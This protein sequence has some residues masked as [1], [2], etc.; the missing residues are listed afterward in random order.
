MPV[1]L[2]TSRSRVAPLRAT[3]LPRLELCGALLLAELMDDTRKE[4]EVLNIRIKH[5]ELFYW[6]DSTIVLTWISS[7]SLFQVY[8]SNRIARIRDTTSPDQWQHV[9]SKDNPAA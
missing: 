7:E 9:S 5:S 4:F 1:N 8:V 3:T 2:Y 6:C